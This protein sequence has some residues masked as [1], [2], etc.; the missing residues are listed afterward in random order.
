MFVAYQ[1]NS[2]KNT[3]EML[4]HHVLEVTRCKLEVKT[5]QTVR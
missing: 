4:C 1:E 3:N 5:A 2:E